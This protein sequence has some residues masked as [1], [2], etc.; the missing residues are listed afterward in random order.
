MC[1]VLLAIID[2]LRERVLQCVYSTIMRVLQH[3]TV[4]YGYLESVALCELH[5]KRGG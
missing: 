3:I 5:F 2:S 4:S 1:Q